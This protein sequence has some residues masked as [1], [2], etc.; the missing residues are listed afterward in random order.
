MKIYIDN[1]EVNIFTGAKV[2]D[3]LQQYSEEEFKKVKSGEKKIYDNYG[4]S[5]DIEGELSPKGKYFIKE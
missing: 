4:N 3:V 5:I 1:T 2:K